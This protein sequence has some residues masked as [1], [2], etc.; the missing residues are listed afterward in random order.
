[1]EIN[2]GEKGHVMKESGAIPA[3]KT[4]EAYLVIF[5]VIGAQTGIGLAVFQRFVYLHARQDAI[6]AVALAGLYAH[7]TM[8]VII[9]TLQRFKDKDIYDIHRLVFGKW[10]GSFLNLVA[11]LYCCYSVLMVTVTYFEVLTTYMFPEIPNWFVSGILIILSIYTIIGGIRV[12][13]GLC[14]YSVILSSTVLFVLYQLFPYCEIEN[15]LPLFEAPFSKMLQ[16]VYEMS[17]SLAGFEGIYFYY[18]YIQ[19]KEKTQKYGQIGV[20]LTNIVFLFLI[21]LAIGFF[22]GQEIIK[23]AWPTLSMYKVVKFPFFEQYQ[24]IVLCVFMLAILPI[25][26][27]YLWGLTKGIKKHIPMSQKTALYVVSIILF[28]CTLWFQT[29]SQVYTAGLYFNKTAFYIVFVY[30][31]ILFVST[32]IAARRKQKKERAT[33]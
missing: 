3:A 13:V 28:L 20:L 10:F 8:F 30:P 11:M 23:S 1:M 5:A 14:F 32:W 18:P 12:V 26:A 31:Y 2:K 17:L 25:I 27:I 24:V 7:L 16:A 15:F 29:R 22:G 4:F 33:S 6:F 19:N 21:V 9:R